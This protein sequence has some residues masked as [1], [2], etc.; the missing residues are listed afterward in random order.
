MKKYLIVLGLCTSF[1]FAHGQN[2]TGKQ[3]IDLKNKKLIIG[4]SDTWQIDK[5]KDKEGYKRDI[6]NQNNA[7]RNAIEKYWTF[8]VIDTFMMKS[9]AFAL[10]KKEP[11]KWAVIDIA[12]KVEYENY[13]G[14]QTNPKAAGADHSPT[15]IFRH[16]VDQ[17]KYT[18][19]QFAATNEYC[20]MRL[21]APERIFSVGLPRKL[22]TQADAIYG[23]KQIQ[24]MLNELAKDAKSESNDWLD[25]CHGE[26]LKT[27]TLLINKDDVDEDMTEADMKV[28]YKYPF[29]IVSQDEIDDAILKETAD[30]AVVHLINTEGSRG[31]AFS[32]FITN[33]ASGE[34]YGV[35]MPKGG[36][37]IQGITIKWNARIKKKHFEKIQSVADCK[38]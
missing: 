19:N 31:Q 6:E 36:F 10:A 4:L 33:P 25:E 27:K 1:I 35:I 15:G 17:Y 16:P 7:L 11:E 34:I 23:V 32:Q 14:W 12:L 21:Y 18:P 3:A 9:D 30:V 2:L 26:A 24:Y 38:N 22:V 13:G 8:C 28:A 5:V 37:G 20:L 29:R